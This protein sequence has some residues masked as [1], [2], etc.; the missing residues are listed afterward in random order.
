M[1]TPPHVLSTYGTLTL[2]FQNY[3]CADSTSASVPA[4]IGALATL[5]DSTCAAISPNPVVKAAFA[6]APSAALALPAFA[7][8]TSTQSVSGHHYFTTT[9]TPAFD[10][11]N[12]G[13]V[14][15]TKLASVPAPADANPGV[16]PGQTNGAVPWLKLQHIA[17]G[18]VG[19]VQEIYRMNTAGGAAPKTCDGQ[20][21]SFQI[22]YA[23]EY[24]FWG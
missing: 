14:T 8:P 6:A 23:A 2:P 16:K 7:Q 20:P 18:E 22:E 1:S 4:A 13:F 5:Y 19:N 11:V 10:M 17:A 24:W 15:N 21:A 3:T 12:L 9:T